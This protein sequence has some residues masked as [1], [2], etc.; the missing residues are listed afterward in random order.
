MNIDAAIAKD[1]IADPVRRARQLRS[2]IEGAAPA[3]E[4]GRQVTAEVQ[5]ALHDAGL[6]RLYLPRSLR[7]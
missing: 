3:I 5:A 4:Q 2:L 7:R 1:Q 6:F